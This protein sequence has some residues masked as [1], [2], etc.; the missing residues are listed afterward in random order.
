MAER[1]A[2]KAEVLFGPNLARR[3]IRDARL[4]PY[5]FVAVGFDDAAHLAVEAAAIER[6]GDYS[7]KAV[8]SMMRGAA[9][10]VGRADANA[11]YAARR[12]A[13]RRNRPVKGARRWPNQ[14]ISN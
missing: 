7:A 13:L 6:C 10:A 4:R 11:R 14:P 8:A 9:L 5:E 1:V 3:Q 2:L 12:S